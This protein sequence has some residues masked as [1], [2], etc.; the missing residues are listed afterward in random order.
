M[1]KT[2]LIAFAIAIMTYRYHRYSSGLT[3]KMSQL[4]H[5]QYGILYFQ[6]IIM[7]YSTSING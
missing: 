6:K 3:M 4:K 5:F 1:E 2:T 7:L